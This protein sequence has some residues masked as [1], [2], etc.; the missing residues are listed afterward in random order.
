MFDCSQE[1]CYNSEDMKTMQTV[2]FK[3][4]Y[5]LEPTTLD[6]GTKSRGPI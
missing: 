4:Y 5:V 6:E 2:V 1:L 3:D